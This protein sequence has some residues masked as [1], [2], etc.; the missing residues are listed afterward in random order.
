[1]RNCISFICPLIASLNKVIDVKRGDYRKIRPGAHGRQPS[2]AEMLLRAKM[3][4]S[5]VLTVASASNTIN[6]D[7]HNG[8]RM[9]KTQIFFFWF[10]G[11]H[12]PG[13]DG[14][15]QCHLL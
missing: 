14:S 1:M 10:F 7:L 11:V 9:M 15:F 12:L 5:G 8:L 6:T 13:Y 2:G 3:E 4:V